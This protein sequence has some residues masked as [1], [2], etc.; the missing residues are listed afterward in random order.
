MKIR[1]DFVTNS[2]SSSFIFKDVDKQTL[3]KQLVALAEKRIAE[4]CDEYE[5]CDVEG[6]SDDMKCIADE[7]VEFQEL[8]IGNLGEI[9]GWYGEEALRDIFPEAPKV[10]EMREFLVA[11]STN[12]SPEQRKRFFAYILWY[13]YEFYNWSTKEIN[14]QEIFT[15]K[16]L[17]EM[18]DE[19]WRFGWSKFDDWL[20]EYFIA[21][22]EEITK[23][24]MQF[25]GKHMGEILACIYGAKYVYFETYELYYE[26]ANILRQS[27][28]CMF[29]CS[30]MG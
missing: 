17:N 9:Y 14:V 5:K 10:Q 2:S 24:L 15:E 3:T 23:E 21:H 20:Y 6:L 16:L 27:E 1:T 26:L 11:E 18:L 28:F 22:Y 19:Y 25:A 29:G 12:M 13:F 8:E 7:I 4:P 30:H